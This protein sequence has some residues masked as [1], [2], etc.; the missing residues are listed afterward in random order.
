MKNQDDDDDFILI[1]L[2]FF[3]TDK[4]NWRVYRN[5]LIIHNYDEVPLSL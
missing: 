2:Q 3:L 5:K 1:F 4:V